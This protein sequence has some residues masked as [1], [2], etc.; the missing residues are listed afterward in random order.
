MSNENQTPA[1]TTQNNAVKKFTQA[2]LDNVL[3]RISSIQATGELVLPP[4]YIPENAVRA[5][6]LILQ[7]TTDKSGRPA[8]DV[9]TQPSIANAFMDMVTSGLSVAKNQGYF[10]VYGDRL[11]FDQS[12][13][14]DIA[15]AKR[16]ANVKEVNAVTVYKD[17]IFEYE[18][19]ANSGRKKVL[20]HEQKL[21]NIDMNK[22]VGAYAIVSYND[23]TTDTEIMT[24]GQIQTSWGMG[25]S[26]GNSPAHKNFPDQ[27]AEKTVISRALKIESGSSDDSS[28]LKSS[29]DK[30]KTEVKHE[31][32]EQA[33][34]KAVVFE[35][36]HVVVDEETGELDPQVPKQQPIAD[37]QNSKPVTAPF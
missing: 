26:K 30:A 12:Y 34:S 35:E 24:I 4:N 8:L 32:R 23:G 22:I 14:G 2:T 1:A 15:L 21:T 10:V 7:D 16:V 19:D 29:V 18:V 5:A 27:M 37:Q 20:K 28:I 11:Q 25:G 13:I 6:W 36:A 17:D 9:C 33:N 31:I 3:S